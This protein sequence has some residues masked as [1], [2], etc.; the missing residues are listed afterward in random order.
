MSI[1]SKSIF[2]GLIIL[3][4]SFT[5]SINTKLDKSKTKSIKVENLNKNHLQN[6]KFYKVD[7][8]AISGIKEKAYPGCQILAMKNGE[9]I[10]QKSFG[11]YTYDENSKKVDNETIYDLASIT[12]I[13][14]SSLA[15]MTLRSENKLDYKKTLGFY[16]PYLIGTNKEHL[17]IEEI[18]SHQ[19]GLKAWI[20]FHLKTIEKNG[21]YKFGYFSN[22]KNEYFPTLVAKDLYVAKGYNDT[23]YQSIINSKIEKNGH[24]LYSDL[25]YYFIQQIIESIAQKKINEFVKEI[26]KKIGIELTYLPLNVVSLDQIA[27]TEQDQVF[28]KQLI[29]GYVHDPGAALLGGVSCHAGL[30]GNALNLGKLMQFFLNNGQLNG[31]KLIDN[32]VVREFTSRHFSPNNRRGLCFDKPEQNEK[33]INPVTS[34]CSSQSF[35]HSGFTGTIAWADPKNKLIFVFLCNRVYP[36]ADD[37]KL[38]TL[39]IRGKIHKEFYQV[40]KKE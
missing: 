21:A 34:E 27:P 40:L 7:S 37:N 16:L 1:F 20:P 4:F 13:A 5:K 9:I 28:R 24:Y 32:N 19:A 2:V 12:K 25:G 10:Y 35:G 15:L 23:I 8:I 29:Q 31:V 39:G 22:K 17:I 26:Y 18:L 36:N 30:F 14:A 38:L 11:N 6:S 33:K 3:F